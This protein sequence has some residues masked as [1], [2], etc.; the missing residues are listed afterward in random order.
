MTDEDKALVG[1]LRKDTNETDTWNRKKNWTEQRS[2]R[3]EA[4][5]RI[6]AQ[7]A[8]IEKL[9]YELRCI[10]SDYRGRMDQEWV[11]D[12]LAALGETK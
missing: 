8:E 11:A 7:A 4:A 6:E 1:R 3:R 5:A 10:F 9:R 2:E 12:V